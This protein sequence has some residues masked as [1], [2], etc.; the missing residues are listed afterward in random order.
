M[1]MMHTA[2]RTH[3]IVLLATVIGGIGCAETATI[4]TCPPGARVSINDEVVGVSPVEYTVRREDWPEDGV[5]H[6]R[7][8]REGYLPAE[9]SFDQSM[10]MGRIMG[11]AFSGGLS[12]L[13]KRPSCLQ[14][15][16]LF[17]LE[18]VATAELTPS[19][20]AATH[21]RAPRCYTKHPAHKKGAPTKARTTTES[22]S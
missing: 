12:F 1:R 11:G 9:G 21:R 16:Y 20:P 7:I 8:E 2:A 3:V 19:Q 6:F 17:D 10:C 15:T 13:F 4:R 14:D 22:Q 18:P 5:F